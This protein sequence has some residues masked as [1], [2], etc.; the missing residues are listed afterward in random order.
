M[1]KRGS[2]ASAGADEGS[3]KEPQWVAS[4][5]ERIGKWLEGKTP[6]DFNAL[7]QDGRVLYPD[8]ILRRDTKAD[9]LLEVAVLLRVP[10]VSETVRARIS[11]LDWVAELSGAKTRPT[12]EQAEALIGGNYFDDLDTICLLEHC[13]VDIEPLPDGTNP[14]YMTAKFLEK[15]HPKTSLHDVYARLSFY[16]AVEDPRIHDLT[17]EQF[18]QSVAAIARVR[19]VSP[20]VAIDGRAHGSFIVSMAER[21]ST[22]LTQ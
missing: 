5:P 14:K 19:N 15:M 11:A 9:R 21:L 7:E 6:A 16:Q 2:G 20:L 8:A 4:P 22:L 12:K 1:S 13:I 18:I 17:E 10:T 3:N